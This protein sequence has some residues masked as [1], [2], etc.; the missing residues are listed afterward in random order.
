M[1]NNLNIDFNLMPA[2][3][4]FSSKYILEKYIKNFDNVD[5]SII[6]NS[7]YIDQHQFRYDLP[8]YIHKSNLSTLNEC[9]SIKNILIYCLNE[10]SKQL[11]L[12]G[13]K[14][15]VKENYYESWQHSLTYLLP[16]PV[17][18]YFLDQINIINSNKQNIKDIFQSSSLPSIYNPFID[19]MINTEGLTE[20]HMHFMGTTEAEKVWLDHLQAPIEFYKE[21][22]TTNNNQEVQEQYSQIDSNYTPYE[23]YNLLRKAKFIRLALISFI[24]D[25][26][27]KQI[28]SMNWNKI[29][30]SDTYFSYI[31]D[32]FSYL[33][34]SEHPYKKYYPTLEPMICESIF[35]LDIFK[36]VEISSSEYIH[37]LI[38]LYLL[39]GS[40]FNKLLV[41]QLD[42]YGFDQFQKITVNEIREKIELDY[43]DRF[44]QI[45]GMYNQDVTT[46]EVRFSPKDN[47]FVLKKLVDKIIKTYENDYTRYCMDSKKGKIPKLIMVAHFIKRKDSK[48]NADT[49]LFNHHKLRLKLKATAYTL[50]KLIHSNPEKYKK[51]IKG[52][53]AAANELH[54][55]PEVFA[56]IY[57]YMAYSYNRQLS[58]DNNLGF[59][60]HAGE[61][62]VH[63][64]SG[65]RM[66]YEAVSFLDMPKKSRIGHATA[67]GIDPQFWK[68]RIG[69]TLKIRKG[70][71]LDNL[72]FMNLK[73]GFF[74]QKIMDKIQQYWFEI[75]NESLNSL[76]T[77][78]EAYQ[79]RKIDPFVI[80]DNDDKAF[81]DFSKEER[82]YNSLLG[83][84]L[85]DKVKHMYKKYHTGKYQEKYNE[86]ITITLNEI[87]DDIIYDLQ[88]NMIEYLNEHFVAIESIPTSNIKISFYEN[89]EDHHIFRWTNPSQDANDLSPYVVIGSDDPGIFSNSLRTEFS[90]LYLAALKKGYQPKATIEWL[91][92]LNQNA[93]VFTF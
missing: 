51:Y 19:H 84:N 49:L 53:D 74:N 78:I 10:L 90:Q 66:I 28:F 16:T 29:L 30:Q 64:I 85:T 23:F 13:H 73:L 89:Y 60:F 52:I 2:I 38:H 1:T 12:Y 15:Y 91:S 48:R 71:W 11:E 20:M 34:A 75:Y 27:N 24:K 18:T 76:S 32:T 4:G 70:E 26:E 46:L 56:P 93:K 42:Q 72:I 63:I 55:S 83:F 92:K 41:Q 8:D 33:D 37:K 22:A 82:K 35:L 36:L 88:N 17:V 86:L 68:K 58:Q 45:E 77:A 9:K 67:L 7:V 47:F 65:I 6:Q 50:Q 79:C 54:S 40:Q 5:T 21:T 25:K 61:D 87:S 44:K 59:T 81:S 39:I 57:R 43:Y 31:E 14:V 62:F 80:F 3:L 69:N